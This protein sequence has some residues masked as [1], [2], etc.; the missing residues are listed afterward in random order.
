MLWTDFAVPLFFPSWLKYGN[1][2]LIQPLE[3]SFGAT[4]T[5]SERCLLRTLGVGHVQLRFSF[6][7]SNY[8]QRHHL[9]RVMIPICTFFFLWAR[10]KKL[11]CEELKGRS[12]TDMPKRTEMNKRS[13]L[14]G[15]PLCATLAHACSYCETFLPWQNGGSRDKCNGGK[16]NYDY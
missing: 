11:R 8:S 14:H 16:C 13:M 10:G 3:G 5:L 1:L 7:K 4:I 15:E 12:E 2:W 6:L 9:H